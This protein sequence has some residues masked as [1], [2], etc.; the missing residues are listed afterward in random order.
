M[1]VSKSCE[2][3]YIE[4]TYT[5]FKIRFKEHIQDFLNN[6]GNSNYF[7]YLRK[8]GRGHDVIKNSVKILY[9]ENHFNENNRRNINLKNVPR[10]KKKNINQYVNMIMPE[11]LDIYCRQT[12][13]LVYTVA[14]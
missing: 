5:N 10:K 1:T 2:N 13:R 4:M 6:K 3:F 11:V 8:K 9:V 7:N 14:L 12:F